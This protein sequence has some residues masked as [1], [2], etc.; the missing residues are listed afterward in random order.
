[1]KKGVLDLLRRLPRRY[2]IHFDVKGHT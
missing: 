2:R 1:L